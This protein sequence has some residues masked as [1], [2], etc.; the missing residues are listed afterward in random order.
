MLLLEPLWNA[1]RPPG[2]E[3]APAFLAGDRDHVSLVGVVRLERD[4]E[5]G[6]RLV[7]EALEKRD[8]RHRT[9]RDEM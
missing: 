8:L 3:D 1:V 9:Q 6:D 2:L 4:A 5:G 7:I